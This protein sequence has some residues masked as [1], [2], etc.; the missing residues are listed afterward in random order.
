MLVNSD[1]ALVSQAQAEMQGLQIRYRTW[2][3]KV[4]YCI[5][6]SWP[7]KERFYNRVAFSLNQRGFQKPRGA[8]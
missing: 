7:L 6:Q 5:P 8:E 3:E 2:D 4:L 1:A